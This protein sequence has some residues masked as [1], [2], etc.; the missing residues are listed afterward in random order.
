[1]LLPFAPLYIADLDTGLYPEWLPPQ[2][3]LPFF[4][5]PDRTDAIAVLLTL[6]LTL[7]A[8]I[9]RQRSTQAPRNASDP[10]TAMKKVPSGKDD[11]RMKGALAVYGM[12]SVGIPAPAIV[13]R[14]VR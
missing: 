5:D 12:T 13:G 10:P 2:Y 9:P 3:E 4:S 6:R 11:F 8:T 7:H 14:P 1:M